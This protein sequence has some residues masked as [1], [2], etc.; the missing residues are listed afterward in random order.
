MHPHLSPH[1]VTTADVV[2]PPP[3]PHYPG[4]GGATPAS[5]PSPAAPAAQEE[6]DMQTTIRQWLGRSLIIAVAAVAGCAGDSPIGPNPRPG[7][8][9]TPAAE[10]RGV[11]L[12]S[13]PQLQVEE[14]NRISARLYAVGVQIYRWDGVT[15]VFVAPSATLYEGPESPAPVGTHYAGP[16]W[17]SI[18]GGTVIG[19]VQQRC[20][21]DA[22]AIPWLLLG[23][24]S[25]DGPGIFRG[26]T[27]IQRV[28]TVGGLAP[29]QPGSIIGELAHVPYTTTYLFYRG[30]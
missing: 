11:D 3:L 26:T 29:S 21:P 2:F 14:G 20:T 8:P 16:T 17:E 4:V 13:C 15:W 30:R 10:I 6:D 28:H 19:A 22:S 7:A 23:A 1:P 9:V 12:G 5:S 18:S 27:F 24:V 25:S